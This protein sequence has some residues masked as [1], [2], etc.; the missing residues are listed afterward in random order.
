MAQQGPP[1]PEAREIKGEPAPEETA[2]ALE[3]AQ[4]AELAGQPEQADPLGRQELPAREVL[5]ARPAERAATLAR[6]VRPIFARPTPTA[7]TTR[8]GPSAKAGQDSVFLVCRRTTFA[9]QAS[10]ASQRRFTVCL[11]APMTLIV[12]VLCYIAAL[13]HTYV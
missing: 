4:P 8:V 13:S 5:V 7:L 10:I 11:G 3:P 12:R 1:A 2:G 6:A 9:L